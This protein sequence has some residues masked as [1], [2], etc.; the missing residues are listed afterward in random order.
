MSSSDA[1]N[2]LGR[3]LDERRGSCRDLGIGGIGWSARTL[4]ATVRI[5]AISILASNAAYAKLIALPCR[6]V[7]AHLV[8]RPPV[9]RC[10]KLRKGRIRV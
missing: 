1:I 4:Y 9:T 3:R 7:A 2:R 10:R 6:N 5:A 8:R